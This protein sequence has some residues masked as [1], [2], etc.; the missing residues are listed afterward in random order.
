MGFSSDQWILLIWK[1]DGFFLENIIHLRIRWYICIWISVKMMGAVKMGKELLQGVDFG[2]RMDL[3]YPWWSD[4]C[5][6]N[7]LD[8]GRHF[9]KWVFLHFAS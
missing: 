2:I 8:M 3:G 9:F 6:L 7:V 5:Y 4:Y 1:K